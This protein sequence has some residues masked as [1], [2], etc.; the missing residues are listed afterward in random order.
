MPDTS[1][2][3]DKIRSKLPECEREIIWLTAEVAAAPVKNNTDWA[4]QRNKLGQMTG[5][6][7]TRAFQ[8]TYGERMKQQQRQ[9]AKSKIKQSLDT[10]PAEGDEEE[11]LVGLMSVECS[12]GETSQ[13]L[14]WRLGP[15]PQSSLSRARTRWSSTANCAPTLPSPPTGSTWSKGPVAEGSGH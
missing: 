10:K 3:G 8:E 7:L 4:E 1:D 5:D 13:T 15:R 14:S 12:A 6:E 2:G 11:Q 9:Q